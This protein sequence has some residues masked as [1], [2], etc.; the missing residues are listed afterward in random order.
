M[1]DTVGEDT[2]CSAHPVN[3][4]TAS[5]NTLDVQVGGKGGEG[6]GGELQD[7]TEETTWQPCVL[8]GQKQ[9]REQGERERE[10][11]ISRER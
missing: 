2:T 8:A 5:P 10:R 1:T 7:E 6:R 11:E 3:P 4:A 9:T